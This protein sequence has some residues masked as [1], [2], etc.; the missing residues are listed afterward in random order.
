LTLSLPQRELWGDRRR[1]RTETTPA[2][3]TVQHLTDR[4]KAEHHI[5]DV[6]AR[7]DAAERA[8]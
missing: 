5:T 2:E 1:H 4:L 8:S 6:Q 7:L 3:H